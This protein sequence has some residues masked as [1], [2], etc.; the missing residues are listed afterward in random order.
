MEVEKAGP[1]VVDI[2]L[3]L[4]GFLLKGIKPAITNVPGNSL[5]ADVRINN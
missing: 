2:Q 1:Q 3:A 5:C 4:G